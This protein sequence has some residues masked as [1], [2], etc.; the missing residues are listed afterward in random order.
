MASLS[1]ARL[2]SVF[3]GRA[4]KA[5]SVGAKMVKDFEVEFSLSSRS[6]SIMASARAAKRLSLESTWMMVP[7]GIG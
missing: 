7:E 2:S 1:S 5:A 3:L 6:D 4:S